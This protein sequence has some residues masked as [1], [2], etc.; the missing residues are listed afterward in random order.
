MA[1]LERK[2]LAEWMGL[3]AQRARPLDVR[4][5]VEVPAGIWEMPPRQ[6][7]ELLAVANTPVPFRAMW[8]VS[9]AP[10]EG[11][12]PGSGTLSAS[13]GF[14]GSSYVQLRLGSETASLSQATPLNG[15][16]WRFREISL[17]PAK[18]RQLAAII[19][20]LGR[21]RI[22]KTGVP[23]PEDFVSRIHSSH[24]P[25]VSLQLDG[26]N[27]QVLLHKAGQ[28]ALVPLTT[29]GGWTPEDLDSYAATLAWYVLKQLSEDSELT[30]APRVPLAD[31]PAESVEQLRR[32]LPQ[33]T[34]RLGQGAFSFLETCADAIAN[35]PLPEQEPTLRR[36]QLE[37]AR[38]PVRGDRRHRAELKRRLAHARKVLSE[39]AQP[40]RLAARL[41]S[42]ETDWETPFL[43]LR[44][45]DLAKAVAALADRYAALPSP[46]DWQVLY[47]AR[48]LDSPARVA[49]LQAA[50]RHPRATPAARASAALELAEA[51]LT[52][53]TTD[54]AELRRIALDLRLSIQHRLHALRLL[55]PVGDP[56]RDPGH[57]TQVTLRRLA[58][59]WREAA[60]REL[61]L[62]CEAV[63]AAAGRGDADESVLAACEGLLRGAR[64]RDDRSASSVQYAAGL[65][66]HGNSAEVRARLRAA[67]VASGFGSAARVDGLAR[68]CWLGNLREIEPRLLPAA[69]RGAATP[70]PNAKA[71]SHEARRVLSLWAETDV[72]TRAK[73]LLAWRPTDSAAVHWRMLREL[74]TLNSQLSHRQRAEVAEFVRWCQQ[75]FHSWHPGD[76]WPAALTILAGP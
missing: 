28:L 4:P 3:D 9:F 12:L 2:Q 60:T 29:P 64:L 10:S 70:G 53:G 68:A 38:L 56:W 57:E 62:V 45:L 31:W 32:M 20:W 1:T 36:W 73:L 48:E 19:W 40:D 17:P 18:G 23:S 61:E 58:G 49:L 51:K 72:T 8:K 46:R 7:A 26:E 30:A 47:A 39:R 27:G 21:L 54:F 74:R 41:R 43:L 14:L 24:A 66:A 52:E 22:L 15:P 71:S 42:P 55:A 25:W 67:L 33:L 65:L 59:G 76:L 34:P 35:V 37:L 75:N 69:T 5:W 11:S 6:A 13:A 50:A 16:I 44:R 63:L